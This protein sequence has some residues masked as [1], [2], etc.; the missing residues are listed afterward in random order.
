MQSDKILKVFA[1]GLADLSLEEGVVSAK[2]VEAVLQALRNRP[3]NRLKAILKHYLYYI[4]RE[5]DRNRAVIE[6]AG[7]LDDS[8]IA[9]IHKKLTDTYGR[10]LTLETREKPSLIAG[11]RIAVGDDLYDASIRGRLRTLSMSV[12]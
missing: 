6:Y 7:L 8:S 12:R 2:K 4:K 1:K 10:M 3:P 9:T 11:F 5:I